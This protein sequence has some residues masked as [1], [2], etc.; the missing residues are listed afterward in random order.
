MSED[1]SKNQ[2]QNKQEKPQP[3]L[4]P[5]IVM[6]DGVK[7]MYGNRDEKKEYPFDL[8][9]ADGVVARH[10]EVDKI[11]ASGD[12]AEIPSSIRLA[13]YD[14]RTFDNLK[15]NNGFAALQVRIIHQP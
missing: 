6:I 4:Q 9:W 10:S 1:K 15:K 2:N 5:E 11:G 8:S 7:K 3:E 13:V 14:Q 12:F